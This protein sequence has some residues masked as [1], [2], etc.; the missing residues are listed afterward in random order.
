MKLIVVYVTHP[1]QDTARELSEKLLDLRLIGCY[2]LFPISVGYH[3]KG[4]IAREDEY[5]TL[6]KT[7]PEICLEL[8][9]KIKELHSYEV[10]CIIKYECEVNEEY[11][12]WLN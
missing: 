4:E 3:W 7:L 10:P 12:T 2:N 1:T 9:Q 6:L 8:E 11:Y 5:V